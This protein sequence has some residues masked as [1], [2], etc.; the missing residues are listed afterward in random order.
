ME[1][2]HRLEFE[3]MMGKFFGSLQ[4]EMK[5]RD[6]VTRSIA[7][8]RLAHNQNL[9]AAV[10]FTGNM[11]REGYQTNEIVEKPEYLMQPRHFDE[12]ADRF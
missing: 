4:N 7:N 11:S 9:R 10:R 1:D 8:N 6:Y 12:V 2:N 5:S 3:L